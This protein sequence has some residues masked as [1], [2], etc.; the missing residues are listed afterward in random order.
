MEDSIIKDLY[1]GKF[2]PAE[3]I[4]SHDEGY[5]PTVRKLDKEKEA[6]KTL[7]P[8]EGI[9]H[10]EEIERLHAHVSDM[11]SRADFEYGLVL[12]VLLM[13]EI[14]CKGDRLSL[15]STE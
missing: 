13:N 3:T 9:G 5:L 12:S 8:P 4:L 15:H 7:L 1:N 2:Y 6:L 11:Q 14:F 10:L